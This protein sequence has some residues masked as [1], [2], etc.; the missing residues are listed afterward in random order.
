MS[1]RG[2]GALTIVRLG[3]WAFLGI[4]MGCALT[5]LG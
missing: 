4:G 2:T 3:F 1:A 5:F